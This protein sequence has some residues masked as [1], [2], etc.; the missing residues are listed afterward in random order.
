MADRFSHVFAG[1]C[2]TVIASWRYG[3]I[4]PPLVVACM[5]GAVIPD[6][7]R[8][9]LV[10][11]AETITA[12]TDIPWSW[13]VLHRAGGALFVVLFFPFI[14]RRDLR[15]PVIAMLTVGIASHVIIDYVMWQPTATTNLSAGHSST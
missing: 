5:T 10:F 9:E 8:I 15:L 2:I 13:D 7:T 12:L 14:V 3:W 6:L 4:I 1:M 11:P